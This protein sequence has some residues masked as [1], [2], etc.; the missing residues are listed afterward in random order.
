MDTLRADHVGCYGS[1][2]LATPHID[3]FARGGTLFSQIN[4]QVPLTLPS[5]VSM[6]TL[7]YPLRTELKTTASLGPNAVTLADVLKANGYRTA[8]FV[9]GFVLDRRFGLDRG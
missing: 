6:L 1:N 3:R 5:H 9:G 8:T 2:G 7:T 4:S